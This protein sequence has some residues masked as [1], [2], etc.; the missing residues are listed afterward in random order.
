MNELVHRGILGTRCCSQTTQVLK[1]PLNTILAWNINFIM[2]KNY[3]NNIFI[4]ASR[5]YFQQSPTCT[6]VNNLV[7]IWQQSNTHGTKVL[8]M[9]CSWNR[10]NQRVCDIQIRMYFANLHISI[11]YIISNYMK[12]AVDMLGLWMISWFL[13]ECYGASVV[14]QYLQWVQCTWNHAKLSDEVPDPNSFT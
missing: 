13:S 2:N 12:L 3:N 5:A 7:Y 4:I 6:R 1:F 14:T 9:F 8:I 10:F 11:C